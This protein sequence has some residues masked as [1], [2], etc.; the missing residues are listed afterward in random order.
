VLQEKH[1]LERRAWDQEEDFDGVHA[2]ATRAQTRQTR[3]YHDQRTSSTCCMVDGPRRGWSWSHQRMRCTFQGVLWA[4]ERNSWTLGSAEVQLQCVDSCKKVAGQRTRPCLALLLRYITS[5]I[6]GY[7]P[8]TMSRVA[9][10]LIAVERV[11]SMF[12][13]R[14][15]PSRIAS[16]ARDNSVQRYVCPA[17]QGTSTS[18]DPRSIE[19][20]PQAQSLLYL[21]W[22]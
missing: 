22:P 16:R 15:L 14:P 10:I 11:V 19:R 6:K 18:V 13:A 2:E 3:P 5:L 4:N 17:L 7:M 20:C 8:Q 9:S 12:L 1:G 21:L